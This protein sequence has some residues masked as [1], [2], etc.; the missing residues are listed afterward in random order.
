ME[1]IDKILLEWSHRVHDGMP[2][3]KNPTHLLELRNTM[4]KLNIQEE[5]IDLLFLNLTEG[6]GPRLRTRTEDMH[7]IFFALAY[8]SIIKGKKST[9]NSVSDSKGL[10]NL[11]KGVKSALDNFSNHKKTIDIHEKDYSFFSMENTKQGKKDKDMWSDAMNIAKKVHKFVESVDSS[12]SVSRVFGTGSGGRKV[13]ADAIVKTKK[14]DEISV[15]LK[16]QAGQFNSLSVPDLMKK[17][18]NIDLKGKGLLN[19]MYDNGYKSEIDTAFEYYALATYGQKDLPVGGDSKYTQEDKDNIEKADFSVK[20]SWKDFQNTSKVS[21]KTRK[22]FTH[23]Y[24]HPEN[25]APRSSHKKMKGTLLNNSIDNFLSIGGKGGMGKLVDNLEDAI[26]YML[27]AEP[28]TSYLYVASGGNK[29][30]FI[31]SQ[32]Q[33]KGKKYKFDVKAKT[34]DDGVLAS[35]DYTY[36]V[37]VFVDGIKAFTFDIKWRFAGQAGQWDGDLQHKGSKIVFHSGFAKAFGLPN[38]PK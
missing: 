26:I 2:N 11:L 32:K 19:H 22:A 35:A 33:I 34:N 20:S 13:I 9:Y 36:D 27:R 25:F 17:L 16:Y 8:A 37:T 24:N 12:K 1:I 31:P 23:L 18:Y 10:I 28:K 6:V 3:L 15:S 7:E 38:I 14:G 4:Q 21:V 29:F 30:A 5:A